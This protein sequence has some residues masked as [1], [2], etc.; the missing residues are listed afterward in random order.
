MKKILILLILLILA[1]TTLAEQ[2]FV[3]DK[4][5]CSNNQKTKGTAILFS[6]ILGGN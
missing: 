1:Y 2:S 3:N 6:F 5:D 4:K